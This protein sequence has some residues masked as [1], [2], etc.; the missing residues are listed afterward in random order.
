MIQQR[1]EELIGLVSEVCGSLTY[2]IDNETG[3]EQ[4]TAGGRPGRDIIEFLVVFSN[5]AQTM[6]EHYPDVKMIFVFDGT[7]QAIGQSLLIDKPLTREAAQRLW[8]NLLAVLHGEYVSSGQKAADDKRQAE[9]DARWQK[10]IDDLMST[11]GECLGNRIMLCRWM[12][13]FCK[14]GSLSTV[15]FNA[16]SVIDQLTAAGFKSNEFVGHDFE[17]MDLKDF[18]DNG[19]RYAVG[20]VINCLEVTGFVHEQSEFFFRTLLPLIEARGS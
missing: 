6:K 4:F 9:F 3:E 19:F 13:R 11:L 16:Q 2:L 20:Q 12:L 18:T 14:A 15:V 7:D 17:A 1:A 5:A 10:E 8:N